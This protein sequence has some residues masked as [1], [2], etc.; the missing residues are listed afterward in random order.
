MT[1]IPSG[2][3]HSSQNENDFMVEDGI[4]L[5][6]TPG[7]IEVYFNELLQ[8][9]PR[10]MP[11]YKY[12]RDNGYIW[13]MQEVMP[14]ILTRRQLHD[15]KIIPVSVGYPNQ[16]SKGTFPINGI[17]LLRTGMNQATSYSELSKL[18]PLIVREE[19][20]E[21]IKNVNERAV[22]ILGDRGALKEGFRDKINTRSVS[23]T[24][25]NLRRSLANSAVNIMDR[26]IIQDGNMAD[27]EFKR[28]LVATEEVLPVI[29]KVEQR[30]KQILRDHESNDAIAAIRV[31]RVI[32]KYDLSSFE[33]DKHPVLTSS[34]ILA[35]Y[36]E[37]AELLQARLVKESAIARDSIQEK[38]Y[39]LVARDL[40][41]DLL[42]RY[43]SD[44][45]RHHENLQKVQEFIFPEPKRPNTLERNRL[46]GL[47]N[48]VSGLLGGSSQKFGPD[49]NGVVG[50]AFGEVLKITR[51]GSKTD[52][53]DQAYEDQLYANVIGMMLEQRKLEI[54]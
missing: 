36:P 25:T 7:E 39:R 42:K 48:S 16:L 47:A 21:Y 5:D 11:V 29:D 30:C 1:E 38:T 35:N 54:E 14:I 40:I 20:P 18:A 10:V 46:I 26:R 34:R 31:L 37:V 49:G 4:E 32:E 43:A 24:V 28:W 45:K 12:Q 13:T 19:L 23:S 2:G 27:E 51:S 22:T 52:Q 50:P 8:T 33:T 53:D 44:S 3:E 17:D 41:L 15:R 9:E 6:A